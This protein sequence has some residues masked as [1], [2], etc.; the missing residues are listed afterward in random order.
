MNIRKTIITA[1]VGLTL[2]AT[3]VP[4][5]NVNALTIEELQAQINMLMAQLAQLQGSTPSSPSGVPA[6]CTGI[7]FTRNMTVGATG[8]DVKCL[9]AILNQSASTQVA[10]TGAGSPGNE[11]SYFGPLTLAAVKKFQAQNGM[12]PANQVG[13][14][15]RARLNQ[16]L[17]GGIID[18]G[19]PPIVPLPTGSVSAVL[20][21]TTPVA[22]ALINSQASAGVLDINFVGTGTVTSVTFQRTGISTQN[23]LSAVYLYDGATRITDGYS[24]NSTGSLTMNGLSI[25][26]NG[27]KVISVKV[28][29]ASDAVSYAS[30]IAVSLTSFVANGVTTIS[31]VA[32]NTFMIV[33]GSAATAYMGTNTATST[34]NVN[35]GTSQ[36]TMWSDTVQVNTRTIQ[37]KGMNFKIIGSAPTNALSNIKLFVDG[38]DTGVVAVMGT[39]QGSNYA[40]FNFASPVTLATGTHTIDVRAD[41]VT[42][43]NR[44]VQLSVDQAAD[45]TLF[46]PQVGVNLAILGTAGVTF[47]ADSGT[48]VTILTGSS[49]FVIDPTFTSQTNITAGA[50][51]AT[52]GK[53]LIH[54]YG[55]DVKVSTL[56]ITPKITSGTAGDCT[57]SAAGV[58][59]SASG[60][61]CGISNV[62]LYFNGS[63]VSTQQNSTATG[64]STAVDTLTF[65]LGSQMIIPAG[66]DSVLEVK[67]DMQTTDSV[68]YTAGTVITTVE[69]GDG[70]A[71]DDNAT[72]QSSSAIIDLPTTDVATTGLSISSASL[73]VS[74]NTGYANTTINPNTVNAKIGSYTVQNQSSSEA[75]RLTTLT[76]ALY[77][78]G[79]DAALS[80][81]TTPT[82]NNFS[83]LKTSDTTGSGSSPIQP[84]AS[85]TFSVNDVLQPGASMVIDIFAN[86]GSESGATYA[87]YTKLTVASIGAVSN[88]SSAGTAQTGQT[89][90]LGTGA[91]QT[92]SLVSASS[93]PAQF[94]AS[95]VSSPAVS[96]SQASFN[97]VSTS[98]PSTISELKFTVTGSDANPSQTVTQI[99]VGSA[100]ASPAVVSGTQTVYLT[101]LNLAVPT[102]AGLTQ[103]VLV[104]YAG[105]GSGGVIPNKTSAVTLTY[106]KYTSG[107]TTATLCASGC[108]T[109]MTAVAAPTMTLV[110]SVPTVVVTN[111]TSDGLNIATENKIGEVTIT[112]SSKGAIKVND[113]QF[114]VAS[115]GFTTNPTFTLARI[116]DGSTTVTGSGCGQGTGGQ[117]SQTIF[118]EFGT[119]GNTFTTE[120]GVADVEVNTDFDGYI[121][122]AGTSKTFSL[123]ATVT[124]GNTGTNDA[125]IS[126]S[127]VAAGFNWD[128]TSYAVFVAD[129]S[130]ANPSD[131]TGLTG[132][133][134]YNFPT[135]SYSVHQ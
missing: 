123:Y 10:V 4:V 71:Y 104:T 61:T 135:N 14:M 122:A 114:T 42:G 35:A 76:V 57:T 32:G 1:I 43:A 15:T 11:T 130:A 13:P 133:S 89:I 18:P 38:V 121:I 34:A 27:S 12:I 126:T 37:L 110:S 86:T 125:S 91:V 19:L 65:T 95:S 48:T 99:C 109:A 64:D 100:C 40:M 119:S 45:M 17:A 81:S 50:T 8:S 78:A 101:G 85:N 79:D 24:F 51:N 21:S 94:I 88:I 59:T 33:T 127:L 90:T 54:G 103:N 93:T 20:S 128:D 70:T 3:I 73:V 47:T 87:L 49:T 46:D 6:V 23:T 55:E 117:A 107:G 74:K 134:I 58:V 41:I 112:A 16:I 92:P 111:T 69:G 82:L 118:C 26:V 31:N 28:D 83:A 129:D 22:G 67:A 30:S 53:F 5:S 106:V 113:L 44:T 60:T 102:G 63:Q 84:S 98:A 115:S 39:I 131:G 105:I 68:N 77:D 36:Y 56:Y 66:Q 97:F 52:I 96:G 80:A 75:V 29:T 108:T 124:G 62:T 72:G 7:T 120:T 2:V 9:Q 116:A 25:P 132:A